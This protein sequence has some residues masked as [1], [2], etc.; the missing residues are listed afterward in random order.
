MSLAESIN[1]S[2]QRVQ[3]IVMKR[4]DDDYSER[5]VMEAYERC[6]G[7]SARNSTAFWYCLTLLMQ[8][9]GHVLE[10]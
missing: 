4:K 9:Q 3:S 7:G 5:R 10:T 6:G 2:L 8:V 1:S